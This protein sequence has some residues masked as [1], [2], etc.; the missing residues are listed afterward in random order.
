VL[1]SVIVLVIVAGRGM[2]DIVL[3]KTQIKRKARE[4]TA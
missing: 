2:L 3:D 4:R 1:Q